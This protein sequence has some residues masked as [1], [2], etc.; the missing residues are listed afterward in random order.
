MS[1][2]VGFVTTREGRAALRFAVQEAKRRGSDLVVINSQRGGHGPE[3]THVD[4]VLAEAK[5]ELEE[6]GVSSSPRARARARSRRGC[7][8]RRGRDRRRVHRHRAAPAQPGREAR[9][10][11]QRP[12]HPARRHLPRHLGQGRSTRPTTDQCFRLVTLCRSRHPRTR[13]RPLMTLN[14]PR[15]RARWRSAVNR[16][17]GPPGS[18]RGSPST[19]LVPQHAHPARLQRQLGGEPISCRR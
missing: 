10:G 14:R 3:E 6:F 4:A 13:N 11:L 8:R 15:R 12:A 18:T 2:V 16:R 17:G 7:R 9:H 1:I 5:R 19:P